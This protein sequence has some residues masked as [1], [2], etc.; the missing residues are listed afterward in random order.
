M[1]LE[2]AKLLAG[3]ANMAATP[4]FLLNLGDSLPMMANRFPI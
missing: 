1:L 3:V 4:S 2:Q